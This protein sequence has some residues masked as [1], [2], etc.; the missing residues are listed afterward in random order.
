VDK[1]S[2]KRAEKPLPPKD[3]AGVDMGLASGGMFSEWNDSPVV[4]V[5]GQAVKRS[6]TQ[7][8]QKWAERWASISKA[9]RVLDQNKDGWLSRWELE[10]VLIRYNLHFNKKLLDDVWGMIDKEGRGK[11]RFG[12]PAPFK[13][14]GG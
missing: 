8:L 5:K 7:M 12:L 9:F 3:K 13:V 10:N 11:I 2:L 6:I 4:E 14:C 1:K